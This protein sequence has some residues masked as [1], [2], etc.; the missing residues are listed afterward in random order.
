MVNSSGLD[1]VFSALSD[2]TRRRIVEQLA[3]RPLSVG[4]IA[5]GFSISQPGISRHIKVLEQAGLLKRE[6][7]GRVHRCRLEPKALQSASSWLETQRAFWNS[8]FDRL[9]AYLARTSPRKKKS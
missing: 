3:K 2:P 8:T 1:G 6:V 9:D 4:E 7:T 5:S